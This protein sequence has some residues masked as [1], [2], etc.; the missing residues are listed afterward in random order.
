MTPPKVFAITL[1]DS[2]SFFFYLNG[3]FLYLSWDLIWLYSGSSSQ[4]AA[5]F[6]LSAWYQLQTFYTFVCLEEI[7]AYLGNLMFLNQTKW[8]KWKKAKNHT[9][10]CH[11]L[12]TC[13]A[14]CISLTFLIG[15]LSVGTIMLKRCRVAS[16]TMA[17]GRQKH[18]FAFQTCFGKISVWLF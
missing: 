1:I 16:Q 12:N 2:F 10:L 9:K 5:K 8:K 4:T 7:R 18:R 3:D 11:C 17:N 13:G 15:F 14:K 6:R